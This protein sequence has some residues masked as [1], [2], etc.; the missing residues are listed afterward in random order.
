[1]GHLNT[2]VTPSI[3]PKELTTHKKEVVK[4]KQMIMDA[5]KNHLIPHISEK[6]IAKE[7]FVALVSL[8]QS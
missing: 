5:I 8:Y 7:M 1:M 6:K 4:A 3:D 2:V